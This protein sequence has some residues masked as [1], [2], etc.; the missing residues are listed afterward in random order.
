MKKNF[1]KDPKFLL[2]YYLFLIVLALIIFFFVIS[3]K[4]DVKPELQTE[5]IYSGVDDYG[6]VQPTPIQKNDETISAEQNLSVNRT[7]SLL[8]DGSIS[9]IAKLD[10]NSFLDKDFIIQDF[11]ETVKFNENVDLLESSIEAL[12]GTLFPLLTKIELGNYGPGP[13]STK[14][15]KFTVVLLDVNLDNSSENTDL[16]E[17]TFKID[18]NIDSILFSG[19]EL[20]YGNQILE[21]DEFEYAFEAT[22]IIFL[23]LPSKS[24]TIGFIWASKNFIQL[25]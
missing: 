3:I 11:V 2:F 23:A 21:L 7:I 17:V 22:F 15:S 6:N 10:G 25:I 19:A 5:T 1:Y 24:P 4:Q 12:N 18:Q 20:R 13:V 14:N 16:Y 8:E 9:I